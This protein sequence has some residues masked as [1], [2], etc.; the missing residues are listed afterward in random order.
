MAWFEGLE[1]DNS[2]AYF[3]AHRVRGPFEDLLDDLSLE[4]GAEHDG[5]TATPRPRGAGGSA[6]G[7]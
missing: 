6:A 3:D 1:R 5:P 2:K 7:A 4:F